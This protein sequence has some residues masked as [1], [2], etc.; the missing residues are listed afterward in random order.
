MIRCLKTCSEYSVELC[1][2]GKCPDILYAKVSDKLIYANSAGQDPEG[3]VWSGSTVFAMP[4]S[5][6]KQLHKNKKI[7]KKK[8]GIQCS[9]V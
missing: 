5:I 1:A 9:K 2:Y 8:N 3:A 7:A 6:K 4:L